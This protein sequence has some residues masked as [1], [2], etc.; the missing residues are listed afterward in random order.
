[1]SL[2]GG[3]ASKRTAQEIVGNEISVTGIPPITAVNEN[4]HKK[5]KNLEVDTTFKNGR[6]F[7]IYSE[8]K[9]SEND[10]WSTVKKLDFKV[11]SRYNVVWKKLGLRFHTRARVRERMGDGTI[12]RF[13]N[14]ANTQLREVNPDNNQVTREA[15]RHCRF[16]D[17]MH[18]IKN[19]EVRTNSNDIVSKTTPYDC[20]AEH[21]RWA[22]QTT[23]EEK[24]NYESWLDNGYHYHFDK[25]K[26]GT[27]L[28]APDR[29]CVGAAV[30]QGAGAYANFKASKQMEK[31]LYDNDYKRYNVNIPSSFFEIDH[32]SPGWTNFTV[33]INL[34]P[35]SLCLVARQAAENGKGTVINS[36]FYQMD[37]QNTFIEF[38][39]LEPRDP[40]QLE[41]F[42]KDNQSFLTAKKMKMVFSED[43]SRTLNRDTGIELLQWKEF[44]GKF[45]R[46]GFFGIIPKSDL[47]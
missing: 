10:G 14:P 2:S 1:M 27:F 32:Y 12:E 47:T 20:F 31:E 30:A 23:G 11:E 9:T 16:T 6:T 36:A 42:L 46:Q 43:W 41:L 7:R 26:W 34:N 37:T 3:L 5:R 8:Q 35:D 24:A 44:D 4:I 22:V 29:D 33:E 18:L 39:Y 40:T 17:G 25:P 13:S 45:P 38:Y 19:V 28:T 21:L 15:S